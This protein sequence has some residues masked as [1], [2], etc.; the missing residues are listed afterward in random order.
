MV[1]DACDAVSVLP[2][3]RR[4]WV[5]LE[6]HF[7]SDAINDGVAAQAGFV[8]SFDGEA[9]SELHGLRAD[10]LRK[11]VMAGTDQGCRPLLAAGTD[12]AALLPV[13]PGRGPPSP[14][15]ARLRDPPARPRP[16]PRG[17]RF[18]PSRPPPGS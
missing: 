6:A 4:T 15:P 11:A 7:A 18:V 2:G 17:S 12:P 13:T 3:V 9:V 14:P 1:A 8:N 16:P 5:V 10:F